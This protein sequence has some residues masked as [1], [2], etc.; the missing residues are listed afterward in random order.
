MAVGKLDRPLMRLIPK[1]LV[2]EQDSDMT[3]FQLTHWD[4]N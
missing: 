1:E 4:L 2:M 3:L